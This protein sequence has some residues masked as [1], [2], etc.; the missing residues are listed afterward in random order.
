[1]DLCF[2]IKIQKP[3]FIKMICENLHVVLPTE[4]F[5]KEIL[6]KK[7][8]YIGLKYTFIWYKKHLVFSADISHIG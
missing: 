4:I 2:R 7:Y 3:F 6:I 5:F 1:M 8:G